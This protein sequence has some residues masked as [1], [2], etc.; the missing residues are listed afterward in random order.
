MKTICPLVKKADSELKTIG[1]L[2]NRNAD[3]MSEDQKRSLYMKHNDYK[4]HKIETKPLPKGMSYKKK[5]PKPLWP[6]PGKG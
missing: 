5:P 3:R 6:G 2:A 4:E 1:D